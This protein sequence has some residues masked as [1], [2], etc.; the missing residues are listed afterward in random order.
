MFLYFALR[1]SA[2]KGPQ[3]ILSRFLFPTQKKKVEAKK[4]WLFIF[5]GVVFDEIAGFQYCRA[6]CRNMTIARKDIPTDG[7]WSFFELVS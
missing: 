3:K 2:P 6:L 7:D 5:M 1:H 4:K